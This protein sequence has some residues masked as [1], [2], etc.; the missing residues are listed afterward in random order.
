MQS[1]MAGLGCRLCTKEMLAFIPPREVLRGTLR[2][3]R[4]ASIHLRL[5]WLRRK[6]GHCPRCAHCTRCTAC[7]SPTFLGKLRV[8]QGLESSLELGKSR[9][10]EQRISCVFYHRFFGQVKHFRQFAEKSFAPFAYFT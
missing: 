10:A 7:N 5:Q 4:R 2:N 3:N 9:C 6:R 1:N 8:Q